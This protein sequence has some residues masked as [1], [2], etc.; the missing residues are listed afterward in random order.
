M[1]GL[2]CRCRRFACPE[3]HLCV[4]S[5]S[6]RGSVCR[7]PT[8]KI[9]QKLYHLL[10][11]SGLQFFRL[12]TGSG[13]IHI[14]RSRF[15]EFQKPSSFLM[16]P[17]PIVVSSPAHLPLRVQRL[18]LIPHGETHLS[19]PSNANQH[20][21]DTFSGSLDTAHVPTACRAGTVHREIRPLLTLVFIFHDCLPTFK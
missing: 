12:T 1:T 11:Q 5:K 7:N 2:Y 4:I 17:N 18:R 6:Y 15:L 3:V 13:T 20:Q 14:R 8:R 19:T 21:H 16:Y 9:R 10:F